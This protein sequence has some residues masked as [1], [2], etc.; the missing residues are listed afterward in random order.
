MLSADIWRRRRKIMSLA[1]TQSM[2][3]HYIE[4]FNEQ[5]HILVSEIG[6]HANSNA[7][8]DIYE[9]ATRFTLDVAC[10]T[11]MGQK[12]HS[13]LKNPATQK[14]DNK[15]GHATDRA[16]Q[17]LYQRFRWPLYISEFFFSFSK[18]YREYQKCCRVFNQITEA[19]IAEA[20]AEC[21]K[22]KL[23][24]NNNTNEKKAKTFLDMLINNNDVNKLT[25]RDLRDELNTMVAGGADT[26]GHV[27]GFVFLMLAMFPEVQEKVYDEIQVNLGDTYVTKEQLLQLT[28]T[29][30]VFK[31]T[32]R[33]FP[34]FCL[35]G[36]ELTG[37]VQLKT[38]DITLTADT[39][40]IISV[41]GLHLNK[42]VWGDDAEQFKPDRFSPE[43]CAKRH[44]YSFMG[45]SAG[46]R[47]CIGHKFGKYSMKVLVVNVLRKFKL[48]TEEKFQDIQCQ[49]N[50]MLK[51]VGGWKIKIDER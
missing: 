33:L 8:F 49:F 9:Y 23:M 14:Y 22:L 41:L 10:E 47:N 40:I 43:N 31:E 15:Y 45:F 36:R 26:S 44:L 24:N 29:E 17:I 20:K 6:E 46:S 16:F 21:Q 39:K 5:S 37:D 38:E 11:V 34:L 18:M 13:Q 25:D 1:F 30:Q 2:M 4:V 50:V 51:K 19:V 27:L 32:I 28:Y 3:D 42:A 7:Y 35:I 12:L 48:R